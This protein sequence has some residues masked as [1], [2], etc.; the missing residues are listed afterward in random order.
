LLQKED[1]IQVA[2]IFDLRDTATVVINGAVRKPGSFRYEEGL[3]LKSLIMKAE[4]YADN[5]TGRGIE[6]SRRKRD[7]EVNKSG[8]SIVE[9]IRIDD[10]KE[11]ADGSSDV[12]LKPFDIVTI[13][14]DP[15]YKKQ[16][17]VSISGEVM[18]PAVYTLQ[19]REERL[20]SLINRAGGL[21]YTA[22]VG[23][24]KL[25]RKKKEVVDSSEIKRLLLS[26]VKDT[27]K[28]KITVP[29]KT[30]TDVA[31]DLNYILKHPGSFDDITLEEGDELV[32]P[33]I[34]NTVTVNGEVFRPV[35]IM[36]ERG[37]SFSDY[38][39]DAGGVTEAG[40]RNKA[41]VIYANGRSAKIRRPLGIFT[42]YPKIEPGAN[43]YV[44][45]K[46]KRDNSF[47]AAKAGILI[48]AVTALITTI[49]VIR[50]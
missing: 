3:S 23:G 20:S 45:Q 43:I 25:I 2:S 6:I 27:T 41:F 26:V 14:E 49:S 21:L 5:A 18:M 39:S 13:K 34:N 46:P 10:S 30:T 9:L 38:V 44:P 7:V 28:T 24:A 42:S 16:I 12:V 36:Y 15:F 8:S 35:D 22:N 40:R 50:R 1:S 33:R 37:K 11:L 19:S 17:S 4:G 31:I 48:S 29:E 32:I 47:D